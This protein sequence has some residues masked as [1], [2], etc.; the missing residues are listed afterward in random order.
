MIQIEALSGLEMFRLDQLY[1]WSG[2]M[3]SG[4]FPGLRG[5]FLAFE[6]SP[7]LWKNNCFRFLPPLA[8]TFDCF[9]AGDTHT[10]F[11]PSIPAF[12]FFFSFYNFSFFLL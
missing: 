12:T 4:D 11:H 9:D 3:R 6:V 8:T 1:Y 7:G 10:S 2:E 5:G